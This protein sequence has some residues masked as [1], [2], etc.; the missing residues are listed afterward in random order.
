M[1]TA[2]RR[3]LVLGLS[4]LVLAPGETLARTATFMLPQAIRGRQGLRRFKRL[5]EG[6]ADPLAAD[7]DG[8]TAMHVAAAV[9]NPGYLRILLAGGVSPN[10]RNLVTGRP[11]I[12]S[13][14]IFE[15]DP[16]FDMLLAAGADPGLADRTGNTPLHIAAQINSPARALTLLQAGAPPRARNDQGQT[17]QRYLFMTGERLLSADARR[18]RREVIAWLQQQGVPLERGD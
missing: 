13:A 7:A 12:V 1:R 16:Q 6:G 11:P 5:L 9:R 18:A 3:A 8:D 2:G 14:M 10:A 15:R 17:F 4:G